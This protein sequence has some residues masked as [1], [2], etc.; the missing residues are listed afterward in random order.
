MKTITTSPGSPDQVS[1]LYVHLISMVAAVGGFL[2]T[3]DIVIMSGGI[4][5]LKRDFHLAPLAV[6]FAM[7][8]AMIACFFSPSFG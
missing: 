1:K 8:S 7:T 5:F 3:Y 4:I 2:L 6:G